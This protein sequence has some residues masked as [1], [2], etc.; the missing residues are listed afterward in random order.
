MLLTHRSGLT[1]EEQKA[2]LE[3]I[4]NQIVEDGCQIRAEDVDNCDLVQ[5]L[6]EI[7]TNESEPQNTY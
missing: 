1:D 3:V 7:V 4:Y 5:F 2:S 6:P